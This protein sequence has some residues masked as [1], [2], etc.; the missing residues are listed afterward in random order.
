MKQ[1]TTLV[2]TAY[3]AVLSAALTL[4]AVVDYVMGFGF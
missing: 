4:V 2:V 1:D 3:F